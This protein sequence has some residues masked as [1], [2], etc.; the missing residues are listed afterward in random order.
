M[1]KNREN[2]NESV[3]TLDLQTLL[4]PTS[5]I[6]GSIIISATIFFSNNN[7]VV[8]GTST[9]KEEVEVAGLYSLAELVDIKPEDLQECVDSGK[10]EDEVKQDIEDGSKAGVNGT[11]AFIVGT[12]TKGKITGEIISGAQ[13]FSAF[14][15]VIEKYL[16]GKGD[17]TSVI[18]V[19]DDP[20]KGS[21]KAKVAI[22]EFSDFEC[23]FCQSF[24][25]STYPEIISN[26][27]DL[28]KVI[29]VYKDFPLSFHDPVATEEAMAATCVQEMKGDEAFFE[30]AQA[31]YENTAT[32]GEGVK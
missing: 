29:Y 10:F 24:H 26:Y 23:P 19:G 2:D 16:S 17:G 13:P 8:S 14:E 12:Y 21:A 7:G 3:V 25:Q 4:L 32:N 9:T 5:I 31:I 30:F 15:T 18:E 27:V 6:I 20:V 1:S 28:N 22:V 11:P